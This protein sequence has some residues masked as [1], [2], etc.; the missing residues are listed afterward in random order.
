M[1]LSTKHSLLFWKL[2]K[3]VSSVNLMCL[4]AFVGPT[5]MSHDTLNFWRT[6]WC[7]CLNLLIDFQYNV[8][9]KKL[10]S[11]REAL[12]ILTND[13]ELCQRERDIYKTK[14]KQLVS[15]LGNWYWY[16]LFMLNNDLGVGQCCNDHGIRSED[17]SGWLKVWSLDWLL[18][19]C[20]IR[21][22]Y[23]KP[24]SCAF[25]ILLPWTFQ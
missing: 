12:K 7:W 1:W 23:S 8:C 20:I 16:Y 6:A 14:I 19:K 15:S 5:C 24:L 17:G 3:T 25:H 10:N 13:L 11:K 18:T 2:I 9:K 22:T 21:Y 4:R